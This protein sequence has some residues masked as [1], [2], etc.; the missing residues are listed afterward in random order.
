MLDPFP[1]VMATHDGTDWPEWGSSP[2]HPLVRFDMAHAGEWMDSVIGED[3]MTCRPRV[4][5]VIRCELCILC[6]IWPLPSEAALATYYQTRFYA[7][8]AADAV[9]KHTRDRTWEEQCVY[10]PILAAC[11]RLRAKPQ[12]AYALLDIGAGCGIAMETAIRR[13]W[14]AYGIEPDGALCTDLRRRG[15][16]TRQGGLAENRVFAERCRPDVVLLHEVLEHQA[17]P[18]AFLLE[19]Y[20]CMQPGSVLVI[21]V[22]NDFSVS[23]LLACEKY[24][25]PYYFLIPPVHV[26]YFT[27]KTLQLLVRR[28][29]FRILDLRGTYPLE[30]TMLTERGESYVGNPV[31]WRQCTDEKIAVELSAVR[32][33]RWREQEAMYRTNI[34]D[35]LGRSILCIAMKG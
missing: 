29:G 9:A 35:R 30:V 7:T 22:P 10:G 24:N 1:F 31:L 20:D 32:E 28:T 15:Y 17:N 25:L 8:V 3:P 12:D 14:V 16:V 21:S 5:H 33:G 23:Q 13:G 18:E 34:Q 19:C 11:E 26:N 27:P 4:Y 6:H 2:H